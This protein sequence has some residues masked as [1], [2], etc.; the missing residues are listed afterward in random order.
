MSCVRHGVRW[1]IHP[2]EGDSS[3]TVISFALQ[4]SPAARTIVGNDAF[5]HGREGICVDGFALADGNGAGSRVVPACDDDPLGI[6]DYGAV[7]Q[8]DVDMVYCRQ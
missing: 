1:R 4:L 3:R 6:G 2:P 8:E 7:I 5:E